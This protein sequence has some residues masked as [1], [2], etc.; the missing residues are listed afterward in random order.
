MVIVYRKSGPLGSFFDYFIL[1]I[2][3]LPTQQRILIAGV[4][5]MLPQHVTKVDSLT[6]SLTCLNV[7]NI[8]HHILHREILD[9]IFDTSN[10][11]TVSPLSS[12]YSDYFFLFY[13]SDALILYRIWL[14]TI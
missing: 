7:H 5:Q 4:G 14:S 8:Q 11:S 6:E 9:L 3:E 1:L 2:N 13:K 12:P 10:S